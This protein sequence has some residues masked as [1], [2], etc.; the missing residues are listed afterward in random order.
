MAQAEDGTGC[1]GG[2]I[3]VCLDGKCEEACERT[4]EQ[5][6]QCPIL[7]LEFEICCPGEYACRD[8][9]EFDTC[10]SDS[11]EEYQCPVSGLEHMF[12]CPYFGQCM[13]DCDF[14]Y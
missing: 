14:E 3:G 8:N 5:E 11:E 6:Y 1:A 10:D 9:C 4:S 2:V 12:C 7:G 13:P